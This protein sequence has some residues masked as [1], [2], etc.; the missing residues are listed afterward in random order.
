[1]KYRIRKKQREWDGDYDESQVIQEILR[2]NLSGEDEFRG[3]SSD[4]WLKISTHPPFYDAL[5]NKLYREQYPLPEGAPTEDESDKKE[6]IQ[7]TRRGTRT[8]LEGEQEANDGTA[9]LN[10]EPRKDGATLHQAEIDELFS[11]IQPVPEKKEEPAGTQALVISGTNTENL[12]AISVPLEPPPPESPPEPKS[13]RPSRKVIYASAAALLLLMLFQFSGGEKTRED[14]KPAGPIPQ[15]YTSLTDPKVRK[16]TL[17]ALERQGD[18]LYSWHTPIFYVGAAQVYGQALSL[19]ETNTGILGAVAEASARLFPESS[20]D[21]GI[22][23]QTRQFIARGRVKEPHYTAFY[24]SE[25]LLALYKGDMKA[26]IAA[27]KAAKEVDPAN[28]EN[29]VVEGE[30]L[31]AANEL[32]AAEEVLNR[33]LIDDKYN[34]QARSLLSATLLRK[35]EY[36]KAREQAIAVLKLNPLHAGSYYVLGTIAFEQDRVED[37]EQQYE[38]FVG[39]AKFAS[40]QDL[41]K[42]YYRL[43]VIRENRGKKPEASDAFRLAYYY[44]PEKKKEIEDKL[45]GLNLDD[46]ALADLAFKKEYGVPYFK[47]R[48]EGLLARKNYRHALIFLHATHLLSPGD[49]SALV[50]I[51]D[52]AEKLA[53]N[54]VEFRA[55]SSYY[56]RAIEKDPRLVQAYIKL[57]LLETDLYN[58]D[59]AYMLLKQAQTLAPNAPEPYIALGKYFYKARDY[60]ASIEQFTKAYNIHPSNPEILYYAGLLRPLGKAGGEKEAMVFFSRAYLLNPTYY[61]AMIEW[62][63]LKVKGYDKLFAV[64]F[65]RNLL[66]Q[67]PGN[68]NLYWAMGEVYAANKEHRRAIDYFKKALELD[69]F[70][71]TV[72]L[73]MAKSLEAVGELQKAVSEYREVTNLDRRNGEGA[74][75]AAEILLE[76]K[77]FDLAEEALNELVQLSP[78]YPGAYRYLAR[79]Y[80]AKKKKD[81]AISY[82]QRE[83]KNN[84][85]NAKFRMELASLL[86]EYQEYENAITELSEIANLGSMKNAP[87]YMIEKIRA[88]LLLSRCYRALNR[89]ESA[90]GSITLALEI[91]PNDPELHRELG[92]VYHGQQRN[93]EAVKHFEEY[94]SRNPAAS[95]ATNIRSMI[96]NM[97]IEE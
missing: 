30:I 29:N 67:D 16:E 21:E 80:Q 50:R 79:I 78:N 88:Y 24:R 10:A 44:V 46:N 6:E 92:Y 27:I 41:F 81:Q 60:M 34:I 75:R 68:A 71:S 37:A 26:S 77:R 94:L 35:K 69:Q 47:E 63:K 65:L 96:Q 20:V 53:D 14:A 73:S 76:A 72:R 32:G 70:M 39:L 23:G 97:Q 43:G 18:V 85:L 36:T 38:T 48:A 89:L 95:D 64:K 59:R 7:A 51:G 49:G 31:F 15:L 58:L 12:P 74:Y 56:E 66:E 13:R 93:R 42:A 11:D 9:A 84:P 45:Q 3:T 90:E 82:M 5:L 86:M 28:L 4:R 55:V 25:A 57:G 17:A 2:A 33:V 87:E 62:L 40:R 61:E 1:M 91:D 8:V 19:D 22:E 52:V 83:V 54:Y